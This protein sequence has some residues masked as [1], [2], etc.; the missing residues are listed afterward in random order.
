MRRLFFAFSLISSL[1]PGA[2]HAQEFGPRYLLPIIADSVPGAYGSTW[3]TE[4]TASTTDPGGLSLSGP[5]CT[6]VSSGCVVNLAPGADAHQPALFPGAPMHS[7]H[8]GVIISVA[9]NQASSFATE[10]RIRDLSRQAESAGTEIPVVALEQFG[11]FIRL[12]DVPAGPGTRV[13]LRIYG[14]PRSPA[15][16]APA[17]EVRIQKED[18]TLILQS[19]IPLSAGDC[20]DPQR[21]PDFAQVLLPAGATDERRR[22][23]VSNDL[24]GE[25]IWA[26]ASITNNATQELT[27]VTPNASPAGPARATTLAVGHW[28]GDRSCLEVTS[29]GVTLVEAGDTTRFPN[30]VLSSGTFDVDGLITG[31]SPIAP[32][33]GD[34]VHLSGEVADDTVTITISGPSGMVMGPFTMKFAGSQPCPY[35]QLIVN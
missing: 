35:C 24:S 12:L 34:P 31:C 15:A 13:L 6:Q 32:A 29:N 1:S 18:G 17:A 23:D 20:G 10:L 28:G 33:K 3:Q 8:N 22:I 25:R 27:L 26:F 5:F 4:W 14:L 9:S 2:T 11:H 21:C 19:S 30:P 7:L 16:A